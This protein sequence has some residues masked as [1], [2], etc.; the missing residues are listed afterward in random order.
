MT[1]KSYM[2]WC[3]VK[4]CT[5]GNQAYVSRTIP[6]I[7]NDD[8]WYYKWIV[9]NGDGRKIYLHNHEDLWMHFC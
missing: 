5:G 4:N 7:D 2:E 9:M 8:G 3:L 1:L 6:A